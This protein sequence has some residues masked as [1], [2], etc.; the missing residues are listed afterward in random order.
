MIAEAV[1]APLDIP[2]MAGLNA[3]VSAEGEDPAD[4][5]KEYLVDNGLIDC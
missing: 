5:A 1:L 3:K 4:V 2:T